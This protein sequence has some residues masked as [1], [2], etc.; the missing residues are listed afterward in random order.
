MSRSCD[1]MNTGRSVGNNVSKSN[2]KTRRTFLPNLM[3]KSYES[4]VLRKVFNLKITTRT[5]KT[6]LKYG[7]FDNFLIN[8][9]N[10]NLTDFAVKLKKSLISARPDLIVKSKEVKTKSQG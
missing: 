5:N 6:V 1:L 10:G 3:V 7:S 2:R 9:K 8:V 4:E